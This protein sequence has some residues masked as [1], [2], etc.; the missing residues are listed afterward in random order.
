VNI[1]G[2]LLLKLA[3][4]TKVGAAV[5]CEEQRDSMQE[6]IMELE[7]WAQQWQ[8]EFNASKCHILHLGSSAISWEGQSWPG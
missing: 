1:T 6:V 3:D 2:S 4:D 7:V 8:M 5:E